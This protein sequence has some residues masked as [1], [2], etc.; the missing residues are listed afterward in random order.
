MHRHGGMRHHTFKYF[1]GIAGLRGLQQVPQGINSFELMTGI[2]DVV[3]LRTVHKGT[4]ALST[5]NA[6]HG[7]WFNG[8]RKGITTNPAV[9]FGS[10]ASQTLLFS[11]HSI[12][13]IPVSMPENGGNGSLAAQCVGGQSHHGEHQVILLLGAESRAGGGLPSEQRIRAHRNMSQ[14]QASVT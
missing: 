6:V 11:W 5:E 12:Y 4:V 8:V 14:R 3:A 1:Q 2:A 7:D 13:I 10:Q 9:L